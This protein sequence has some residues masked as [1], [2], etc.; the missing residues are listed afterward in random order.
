MSFD[1]ILAE[2]QH[3]TAINDLL[4]HCFRRLARTAERLREGNV[5][6]G[7]L[8]HLAM[9]DKNALWGDKFLP[10]RIGDTPA[11]LL[12]P[13]AASRYGAGVG[14]RYAAVCR[15][16]MRRF[17]MCFWSVICPTCAYRFEIAPPS[18][19]CRGRLM[20][21]GCCC[22]ALIWGQMAMP[23]PAW[24]ARHRICAKLPER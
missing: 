22:A 19:A 1:I 18:I 7:E 2:P 4:E 12:G 9:D 6:I 3:Q 23:C 21:R 24:F 16:L 10:I 8:S 17:R 11:L 14:L 13:L 15:R 5:P 20:R